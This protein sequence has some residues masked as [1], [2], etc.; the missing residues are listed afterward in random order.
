MR[1]GANRYAPSLFTFFSDDSRA[2]ELK[3]Y[4][5]ANLPAASAPEVAKAVDEIQ[6]R[7]EFKR[8][9]APQLSAWIDKKNC[10][11]WRV[12][13]RTWIVAASR[14]LPLQPWLQ[15]LVMTVTAR[16]LR[17]DP[18]AHRNHGR[19]DEA[20]SSEKLLRQVFRPI[21]QQRDAKE[22]FLLRE[23]DRVF[24]KF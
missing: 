2:D 24:E 1:S 8:R 9:L 16:A 14:W 21:G 20:V 6:F 22:I 3:A 18:Q 7:S 11:G 12:A 19:L 4:A 23:I 5:K 10:R 17:R 15:C 13:C